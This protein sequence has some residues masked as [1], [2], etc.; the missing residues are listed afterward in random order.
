[1]V[2]EQFRVP[3]VS[4]QHCVHAVRKEVGALNGVVQVDVDLDNKIVTVVHSDDVEIT[5]IV[6][7]IKEAGYDDVTP[8][9]IAC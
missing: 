3:G 4:C 9:G 7:A 8:L 6:M 1:M 2:T 5:D